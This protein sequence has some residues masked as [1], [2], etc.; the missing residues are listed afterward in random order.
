MDGFVA[1]CTALE[2]RAKAGTCPMVDFLYADSCE[3]S[4]SS[5]NPI[6]TFRVTFCELK[7]MEL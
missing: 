1:S 3:M 4:S 7:K 6:C 5:M 2:L